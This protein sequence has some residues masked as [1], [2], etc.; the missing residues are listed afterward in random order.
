MTIYD[1]LWRFMSMESRDGNC[2]KMSQIVVTCRK[3]SWRLSQIVV[4]FF[5]V[6]F[7]PSPFGFRRFKFDTYQNAL[8]LQPNIWKPWARAPNAP[9]RLT[10]V[11]ERIFCGTPLHGT[12][13]SI[14]RR[15]SRCLPIF[16]IPCCQQSPDVTYSNSE[17]AWPPQQNVAVNFFCANIWHWKK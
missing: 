2:H 1:V 11:H 15:I 9:L 3:L 16:Q 17:L 10:C 5:P 4:T 7:P 6:P 14:N 12:P 8:F 13:L